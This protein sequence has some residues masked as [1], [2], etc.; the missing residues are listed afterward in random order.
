M[1][2]ATKKKAGPAGNKPA[3][4]RP[5]AKSAKQYEI[6]VQFK[7]VNVPQDRETVTI[8]L[9]IERT[10]M[11][12]T[13][14]KQLALADWLFS[15]ARLNVEL[16]YDPSAQADIPGQATLTSK[17][18]KPRDDDGYNMEFEADVKSFRTTPNSFSTTLV[19]SKAALILNDLADYAGRKGHVVASRKEAARKTA[20]AT[21]ES[22]G[23]EDGDK[24]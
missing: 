12:D 3:T 17:D 10:T 21:T 20:V 2:T 15:G 1:T 6:A 7:G 5:R 24:D 16:W 11:G 13:K 18:Q 9:S 14:A 4:A 19:I 22:D 23:D 8:G